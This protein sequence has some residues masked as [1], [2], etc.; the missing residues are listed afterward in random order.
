M[1]SWAQEI[2]TDTAVRAIVTEPSSCGCRFQQVRLELR[3]LVKK[4]HSI[5]SQ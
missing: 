3:Q 2:I 5:V 4:Q 1:R